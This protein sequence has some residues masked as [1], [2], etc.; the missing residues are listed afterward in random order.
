MANLLELGVPS[1][2]ET[3]PEDLKSAIL[4]AA[5]E[6]SFVNGQRVHSRGDRTKGLSIIQSGA[7]KMGSVGLDGSYTQVSVLGPGQMFGEFT[8][9]ADMPRGFDAEAVGPTRISVINPARFDRLLEQHR[10]IR[11]FILG[12]LTRRLIAALEVADD[13]R[14]LPLEVR[15]AKT[16]A[17]MADSRAANTEIKVKQSE[18]AEFLGVSRMSINTALKMLDKQGLI[19]R[20]YGYLTLPDPNALSHW[21]A[22]RSELQPLALLNA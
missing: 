21:V 3:L 11:G 8:L 4:A 10:G 15:V 2:L 17:S 22:E 5:V 13:M 9:F 1:L 16:L 6:M 19:R 14:R 12:T 18:L 7:V 20:C